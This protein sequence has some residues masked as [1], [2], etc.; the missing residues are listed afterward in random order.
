MTGEED[1]DVCLEAMPADDALLELDEM[2][3]EELGSALKAGDLA[4]A[5]IARPD[6]EINSSSLL[7]EAVWEETKRVL[8]AQ[9][10][11][12]ILRN[13]SDPYYTLV[14]EFQDVVSKDSPWV[15]PPNRGVRHEIDLVPGNKYC[16]LY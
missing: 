3:L 14:K 15:L 1:G 8:N 13:P 2:S 10:E 9:S 7:D 5:V 12:S 11:S 4:K 6:D 16:V